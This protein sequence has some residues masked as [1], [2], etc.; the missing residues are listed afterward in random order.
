MTKMDTPPTLA[1]DPSA[2]IDDHK[3]HPR[4]SHP[5]KDK[6]AEPAA[7]H[8]SA[9][10]GS[11]HAETGLTG[12]A[13]TREILEE[14]RSIRRARQ[15]SDFSMGHLIGS[16][17]QAFAVCALAWALYAAIS[18]DKTA[19]MDATIRVLFAI[20]FQMMA[21]TGFLIGSRGK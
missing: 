10:H 8:K 20:A 15:H 12:D 14:L 7:S 13:L 18:D 9:A 1:I 4:R 21:M 19:Y 16:V 6:P 3:S 17:M 2:P 11:H 5:R